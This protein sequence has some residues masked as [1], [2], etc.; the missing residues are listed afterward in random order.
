MVM[1]VMV[2]LRL[3]GCGSSG[4]NEDGDGSENVVA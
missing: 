4:E 2:D 1:T 3:G